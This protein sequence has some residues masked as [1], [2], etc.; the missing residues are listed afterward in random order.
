MQTSRFEVLGQLRV[1]RDDVRVAVGPPQQQAML[2]V[3]LLRAGRAAT[4]QE[5]IAGIW[6]EE[7]PDTA[8]SS[9]RTYAWRWR[10]VLEESR[11]EPQVLV[12]AGDGYRLVFRTQDL[13]VSQAEKL[14]ATA[15]RAGEDGEPEKGSDLLSQALDLWRGDALAGIPGPFAEQQR[16]RLAELRCA[17]WEEQVHLDLRLGRHALAI[18]KLRAFTDEHPLRERPY[19]LL[20]RALYAAGRQADA[21]AV[22]DRVGRLLDDELGVA[23]GPELKDLRQR[24]LENDPALVPVPRTTALPP[25]S[26]GADVLPG[27]DAATTVGVSPGLPIPA[28]LPADT[29]DFTGRTADVARLVAA[30]GESAS[31]TLS[32]TVVAGMA[33]VGKTALALRAAHQVRGRFPDGRLYADLRGS[34]QQPTEARLVL[35]SFLAAFGVTG[36]DLPETEDDRC[37]LYRS[38]LDGRRVLVVL[39]NARDIAQVLPLLPGSADCAVVIT[40]RPRLSGLPV[41]ARV[42]LDVFTPDEALSLLRR[43][44]G[45]DRIHTEPAAARELVDTCGCLPLAIRIVAARLAARPAWTVAAL[46]GRLR[47]ERRRIAELRTGNLAV[48]TAFEWGYQQLTADQ[49]RAFRLI[50]AVG[51]PDIGIPAAAAVLQADE[52][53][54]E[55]LLES[56][57]DAA[58][59]ESPEPGRYRFHDLLA[60]FA[61]QLAADFDPVETRQ[62]LARLLDFLLAGASAAFQLM[63]PGDAALSV[64]PPVRAATVFHDVMAARSWAAAEF[65]G[66][67]SAIL[68][69]LDAPDP[70]P[71]VVSVVANLLLA[72]SAFGSFIRYERLE[73]AAEAV[74]AAAHACGDRRS[75][76]RAHFLLGNMA[77]QHGRPAQALDCTR[78]AVAICRE[79]GDTVILQQALN[80]L[81]LIASRRQDFDE[82]LRCFDEAIMLARNLGQRSGELVATA[83]AALARVQSGHP[84]EALSSCEAALHGLRAM[85]D[86]HGT[87][88]ALHVIGRAQHELGRYDLAVARYLESLD[89]CAAAGIR[90]LEAV[91]RFQLADTLLALGRTEEA[92]ALAELAVANCEEDRAEHNQGRA[93][94]VLGRALAGLGRSEAAHQ[95]IEQAHSLLTRAGWADAAQAEE[96]LAAF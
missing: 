24:I 47:D 85:A 89:V 45:P 62:A 5:I 30:L 68:L 59:V 32:V 58:M 40:S 8:L 72:F 71:G 14:A 13:D 44:V 35:G 55:E 86:H 53:V 88:F 22:Y 74:A 29:V 90:G 37:R 15:F 16:S 78:L 34:E 26:R 20:M 95:R 76:G 82:A 96:L 49:A 66:A 1:F 28:Q 52:E 7:P 4:V 19:G 39:D 73:S 81:G 70:A 2:A 31:R 65:D 77:V 56:L 33:G 18:P 64:A 48:S 51:A 63:V 67:I 79:V 11:A 17:L 27:G 54:A 6:G 9:V 60:A 80:D 69:A 42:D 75:A 46:N 93:L 57:V 92:V 94:L 36:K 41:T 12:S 23:P 38:L 21:L 25:G 91:T 43:I 83:N 84:A 61:R 10:R 50:G 3:L 87:A